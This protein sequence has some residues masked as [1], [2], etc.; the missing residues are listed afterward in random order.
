MKNKL[1]NITSILFKI[2]NLLL[3]F[4]EY[5][6]KPTK[7]WPYMWKNKIIHKSN[8]D[9]FIKKNKSSYLLLF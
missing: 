9:L 7:S 1:K 3:F 6:F 4:S 2:N 8:L 5:F